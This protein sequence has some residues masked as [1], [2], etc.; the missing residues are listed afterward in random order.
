MLPVGHDGPDHRDPDGGWHV[1][2]HGP[3]RRW[4]GHKADLLAFL[5]WDADVC[6]TVE[7][8]T[9]RFDVWESPDEPNVVFLYEAYTDRDAFE[10]H[11][12]NEPF[13][14]FV[15]EIVP[16]LLEPP[17]F[18]LTFTKSYTSNADG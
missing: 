11:K 3:T 12:A 6:R 13:K 18:V 16:S 10:A 9:L 15:D 5:Q 1:R 8:G 17:G 4:R 2:R 14:R 7:P